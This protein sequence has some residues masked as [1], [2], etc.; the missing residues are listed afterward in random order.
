[1][2][3]NNLPGTNTKAMQ[4]CELPNKEFKIAILGQ[5]SELPED[6]ERQLKAIRKTMVKEYIK[7]SK[8]SSNKRK[9]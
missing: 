3:H 1:M 7:R 2:G 5:L 8:K 6:T 4:I 9:W